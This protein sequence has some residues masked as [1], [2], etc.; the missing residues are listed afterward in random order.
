MRAI[1]SAVWLSVALAMGLSA[2]LGA[3]N[4]ATSE[5][6]RQLGLFADV[7]DKIR[8]QYVD[9]V[10]ESDVIEAAINGM[11]R[12]LDPHSSYMNAE[13]YREM[14]VQ[15]KGEFGGVGMEVTMENGYVKIITPIDETPAAEA[16]L[17][18]GDFIT[19][20]NGESVLGLD[21]SEAVE[22]MRGPIKTD[23]T[24][25]IARQTVD[26]PFDVTVTRDTIKIR[27]VRQEAKGNVGYVR[28]SSF[29]EQ[30]ED[31]LILAIGLLKEELN[32]D[33]S[34]IVLDLRN[35]PGGL[36]DQAVKV[37][38]VFLDHGEVVST[39]GREPNDFQRYSASSGDAIDGRPLIIL[40]NHG[41]A[42][43]AEIVAGALQ[44]HKRAIVIGT[45]SFGKGSVQTIIPLGSQGAL[46]LTTAQYFTPSGRSIQ[47][48]GIV[49]NIEVHQAKIERIEPLRAFRSEADLRGHIEN[50]TDPEVEEDLNGENGAED[51]LDENPE[52]DVDAVLE[53]DLD[54]AVPDVISISSQEDQEGIDYQLAYALDLIRGLTLMSQVQ[55]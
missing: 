54:R 17:E 24:L 42:S 32:N 26:E 30:T 55:N 15:T 44:D 38:D 19:H 36:L 18:A 47:A 14:A 1:I 11:L 43:A 41:T 28:V 37:T 13:G 46:R 5:T 21:L 12:S 29:N 50:G 9:E 34:G 4:A 2:G 10:E 16:G 48:R 39:R 52:A 51:V 45:Q 27:P 3:A 22:K 31:S 40:I 25:T 20:I 49:P 6:Y 23:V 33:F 53:E 7:F 35:N 8:S